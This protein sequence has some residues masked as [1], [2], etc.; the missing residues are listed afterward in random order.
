MQKDAQGK[1]TLIA[2][3]VK[4]SS[5]EQIIHPLLSMNKLPITET[6]I[7]YNYGA[8]TDIARDR[9]TICINAHCIIIIRYWQEERTMLDFNHVE[10]VEQAERKINRKEKQGEGGWGNCHN[11]QLRG[12]NGYCKRPFIFRSQR[13]GFGMQL[14]FSIGED[15]FRVFIYPDS[16]YVFRWIEVKYVR[17]GVH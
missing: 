10:H 14:C 6:A 16:G 8:P 2:P 7:T 12:S 5:K 15:R 3:S 13:P 11:L 4:H 1:G 9:L 17:Y